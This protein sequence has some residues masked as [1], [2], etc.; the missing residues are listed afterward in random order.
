[1]DADVQI[2]LGNVEPYH[3]RLTFGPSGL[4]IGDAGSAT[5]TFVNGEKVEDGQTLQEGDRICL[6]P[7]GAKGSAKL[8]VRLPGT[9]AAAPPPAAP[10]TGANA[11]AAPFIEAEA[12]PLIID[13]GEQ[14]ALTL[15]DDSQPQPIF[16]TEPAPQAQPPA[17][18]PPPP[19]PAPAPPPPAVPV[20]PVAPL[21]PPTRRRRSRA[22]G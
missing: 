9:A 14:P 3:A 10:Q 22:H 4:T 19:P 1:M 6:G 20:E 15:E 11:G 18:P 8:V 7:P 12:A 16:Q 13:D 17:E 2:M 21:V 5:G